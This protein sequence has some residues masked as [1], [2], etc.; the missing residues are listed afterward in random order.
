MKPTHLTA[1]A[2]GGIAAE[3]KA[4]FVSLSD[5]SFYGMS[6]DSVTICYVASDHR[7][8]GIFYTITLSNF[9]ASTCSVW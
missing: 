1:H 8:L 5:S 3:V 2:R 6:K 7:T 4:T 9:V